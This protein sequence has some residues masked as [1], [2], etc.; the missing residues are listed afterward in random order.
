MLTIEEKLKCKL[1]NF[2]N[3]IIL[4]RIKNWKILI[5]F[6]IPDLISLFSKSYIFQKKKN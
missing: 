4:I 2:T 6:I 3:Y 5:S 1:L